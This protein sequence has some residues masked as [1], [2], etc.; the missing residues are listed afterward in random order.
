MI[1]GSHSHKKL[2]LGLRFSS[3]GLRIC[4][5][6]ISLPPN[7]CCAGNTFD[8]SAL[9]CAVLWCG[10]SSDFHWKYI[11]IIRSSHSVIVINGLPFYYIMNA[12]LY[13][14]RYTQ[15]HQG[16]D[17]SRWTTHVSSNWEIDLLVTP[18]A[19]YRTLGMPNEITCNT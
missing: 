7:T 18:V 12:L 1:R 13:S 19:Y 6:M 2:G 3:L 17:L 4:L 11:H 14:D 5:L 8:S 15:A 9:L 10:V 16:Y